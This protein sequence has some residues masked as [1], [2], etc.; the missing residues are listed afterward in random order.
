MKQ[1]TA[2][3][4]EAVQQTAQETTRLNISEIDLTQL[5]VTE[6]AS[7]KNKI[8]EHL[9]ACLF[10]VGKH[11][12]VLDYSITLRTSNGTVCENKGSSVLGSILHPRLLADA[13][14]RFETTFMENVFTPVNAEAFDLFDGPANFTGNSLEPI[15][16]H[17]TNFNPAPGLI[18]PPISIT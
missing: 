5:T 17:V 3:T 16:S 1:K 10:P 4:Q 14:R 13:P 9:A 18:S 11:D 8:E 7:L 2:K 15:N 12:V 6:L